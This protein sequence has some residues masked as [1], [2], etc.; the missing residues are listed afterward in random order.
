MEQTVFNKTDMIEADKPSF[1]LELYEGPL[2]LLLSLV[3]EHKLNIHDIPVSQLC[4]QYMD[5]INGMQQLDMDLTSEFLEMAARLVYMKSLSLLP[6]EEDEIESLRAE[7]SGQLLEY[8]ICRKV[9][10]ELR[11]MDSGFGRFVREVQPVDHDK[12]YQISHDKNE[13]LHAFLAAA[14]RGKRFLPPPAESFERIVAR[15]IV[16]VSSRIVFVLRSLW[17]TNTCKMRDMFTGAKSKSELVATFLAVLELV[18]AKR[19]SVSGDMRN[20]KL[21][22]LKKSASGEVAG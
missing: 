22:A 11:G 8:D 15:K 7:L 2:D 19:V 20:M 10:A 5:Y 17:K 4:D 6:T 16:S 18:K 14:G 1:K 3:R 21:T 13:L 12:S 9:A